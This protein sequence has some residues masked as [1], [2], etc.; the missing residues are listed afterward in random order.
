MPPALDFTVRGRRLEW[1]PEPIHDLTAD[2]VSVRERVALLGEECDGAR[3]PIP[4][5]LKACIEHIQFQ[6]GPP[7]VKNRLRVVLA[8]VPQPASAQDVHHSITIAGDLMTT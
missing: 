4:R 1:E 8:M 3:G 5:K 7:R 2:R 6:D